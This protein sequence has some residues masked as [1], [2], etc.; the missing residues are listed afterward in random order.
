MPPVLLAQ[1]SPA[2]TVSIPPEPLLPL[3]T[4]ILIDPPWPPLAAEDPIEIEPVV[5]ELDVPELNT[6]IPLVPNRPAFVVLTVIAPDVLSIPCPL[7]MPTDPPVS[8]VL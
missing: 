1:V 6:K 7:T 5:P 3:P 4:V 2:A 8:T